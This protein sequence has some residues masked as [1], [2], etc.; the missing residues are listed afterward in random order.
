MISLWLIVVVMIHSM[1]FSTP[2]LAGAK[3]KTEHNGEDKVEKLE[4]L[5]VHG[6]YR[7]GNDLS[8]TEARDQAIGK[9]LEEATR[10][11]HS[12]QIRITEVVNSRFKQEVIRS[13]SAM[14]VH[15]VV[16]DPVKQNA[17]KTCFTASATISWPDV[18]DLLAK[19]K[20]RQDAQQTLVPPEPKS[21]LTIW[22]NRPDG[23]FIEDD[24]LVVYVKSDH[25][26]YLK[27]DYFMADGCVVHLVPNVYRGQALIHG[28]QTYSFGG[29]ADPEHILITHPF[30]AE[31]IKA[32]LS[33]VPIE[34]SG[35]DAGRGCDESRDYLQRLESGIRKGSRGA[36]LTGV[37]RSVPLV[38]TSKAVD[39]YTKEKPGHPR[40]K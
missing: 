28:G 2:D 4:T 14:L 6:C 5:Q 32:M 40:R 31:T 24:K 38:T 23:R 12:L 17:E 18:K 34:D 21:A 19:E 3:E 11:H 10:Y 26:G 20:L 29:D 25:D 16:V 27:L 36:K 1:L 39:T 37:D 35:Y 15:S 8:P 33:A 30:G 7:L 22:T 9:A 13:I